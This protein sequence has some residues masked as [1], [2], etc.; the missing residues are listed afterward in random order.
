MGRRLVEDS[1]EK[2]KYHG[3]DVPRKMEEV[4]VFK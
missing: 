2:H 3:F 4:A 1:M